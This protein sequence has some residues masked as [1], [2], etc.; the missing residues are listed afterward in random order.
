[1]TDNSSIHRVMQ[2]L[3]DLAE[4]QMQLLAV[5]SQE[6][7]RK[8]TRAIGL[9]LVAVTL[10]G[11]ALTVLIAGLGVFL[12]E[13]SDLSVG[14]SLLL[15][16]VAV[17]LVVGV[18]LWIALRAVGSASASMKETQSEFVENLRWLKAT[19]LSPRT[20]ARNRFRRESFHSG[21]HSG[22]H[23]GDD[24][25]GNRAHQHHS[26]TQDKFDADVAFVGS[27]GGTSNATQ[28]SH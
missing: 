7:K 2:D 10:A 5:D 3:V 26:S 11:S 21:D 23:A 12:H 20:S 18:M 9:S 15:V 14:L 28:A 1:M 24:A 17:F 27:R 13:S 6:A 25:A 16:A 19:L 8:M 4:L 22:N